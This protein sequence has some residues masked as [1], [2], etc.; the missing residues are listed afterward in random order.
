MQALIARNECTRF[1]QFLYPQDIVLAA[2][3]LFAQTVHEDSDNARQL[4]FPRLLFH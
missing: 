2:P 1:G 3:V 4:P